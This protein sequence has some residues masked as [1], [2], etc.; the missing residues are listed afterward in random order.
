MR[1]LTRL[2]WLA[3]LLLV[4][5]CGDLFGPRPGEPAWR[6]VQLDA[7]ITHAYTDFGLKLFGALAAEQPDSNLFVSPTSAAFALAMTY[8]G[9]ANETQRA[10]AGV[11]GIADVPLDEVN[12]AN[13]EW[14]AALANTQDR[15][16][17][18]ALANSLWIRR[19]FPVH[20]DFLERN[21]AFYD[22]EV[23]ELDFDSPSAIGTINGWVDRSTRGRIPTIIE[24]IGRDDVMFLINALY[25][26]ADWTHQFDKQ[27][28]RRAPFHLPDGTQREVWMMGQKKAFPY[29]RGDG[30]GLVAL[31]YGNGR[32]SM[33]LALPDHDRA[34]TDLYRQLTPAALD[35]WIAAL[36]DGATMPVALPRFTLEWE[37]ELN[38]VLKALGMEVAFDPDRADFSAMSPAALDAG[39]HI[40]EVKQKTFLKVDEEGTEAAAVTSVKM[41]RV[42]A[43]PMLAFDRPFWM[44]IRDNATG[45]LLF[46]G[47]IVAPEAAS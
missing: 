13:A 36:E 6:A 9:A 27:Q 16:V 26:K 46:V 23:A 8:N 43:P 7:R 15:K 3:P 42:S 47:Q 18:L 21:R 38:D 28:T 20:A 31:P 2:L 4:A 34:L 5:A 25:F 29:Y 30:F 37:A 39:L 24:E 32:F 17:E 1:S 22:A 40:S 35:G 44:A 14:L 12:R 33:L 11:L 19:G 41:S 10:M 45:T